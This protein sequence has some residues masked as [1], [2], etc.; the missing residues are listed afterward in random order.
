MAVL[1]GFSRLPASSYCRRCSVSRQLSHRPMPI[2]ILRWDSGIAR[3]PCLV[4]GSRAARSPTAGPSRRGWLAAI[5][6]SAPAMTGW[7]CRPR[8]YSIATTRTAALSSAYWPARSVALCL[9]R[10]RS[11]R[12]VTRF[13]KPSVSPH[14]WRSECLKR[15]ADTRHNPRTMRKIYERIATGRRFHK[16]DRRCSAG[17]VVI[18]AAWR[19]V[20]WPFLETIYA[21]VC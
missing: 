11:A 19:V 15:A 17:L 1:I 7:R 20:A 21:A 5:G 4:A 14:T 12:T 10:R 6:K 3:L 2:P 18:V 16:G 13:E 8:R 9:R